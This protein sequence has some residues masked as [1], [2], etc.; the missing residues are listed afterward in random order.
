MKETAVNARQPEIQEEWVVFGWRY[1]FI[2]SDHAE[3]F[4][5]GGN[6]KN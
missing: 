4:L 1:S 6:L 3:I 5:V 2:K